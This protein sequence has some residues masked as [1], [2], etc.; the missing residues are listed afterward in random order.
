M[1]K[2][3]PLNFANAG[4]RPLTFKV[5][6]EQETDVGFI[7]IFISTHNAK[8]SD[9][10]Q[11]PVVQRGLVQ[12]PMVGCNWTTQPELWDAITIPVVMKGTNEES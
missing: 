4:A 12:G 1:T 5:P 10:A 3:L 2:R 7:R 8:L 9:I 6:D 11:R